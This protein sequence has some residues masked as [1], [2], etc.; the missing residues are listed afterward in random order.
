M[1][2]QLI[3][4]VLLLGV[5]LYARTASRRS[6]AVAFL[7]AL[8]ACA[9]LYFVWLPAHATWLAEILGMGRGVDLI[10]CMWGVVSMIILLD[11][12]LK[13][14][15]QMEHITALARALAMAVNV[16]HSPDGPSGE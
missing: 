15:A 16:S 8:T 9:G 1:T 2:A 4:T 10:I 7:A 11:L 12:H 6:P 14:R 5:L 13:L 3:L